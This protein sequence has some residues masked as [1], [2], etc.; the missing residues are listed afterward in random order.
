M[1][2][3]RAISLQRRIKLWLEEMRLWV[4]LTL[5]LKNVDDSII[6]DK[7]DIQA[8]IV[9]YFRNLFSKQQDESP[10]MGIQ[11]LVAPFHESHKADMVAPI[12]DEEVQQV[13]FSMPRG[14]APGL[15]GY[16]VEFFIA[17]WF[18][19]RNDVTVAVKEFFDNGKL[20]RACI[21]VTWKKS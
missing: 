15:D 19:V 13:L 9:S 16:T 14:K 21:M 20:L 4:L 17:A 1:L 7:E 8:Y 5:T 11:G 6:Q 3:K 18:I 10:V 2:Q 12:T